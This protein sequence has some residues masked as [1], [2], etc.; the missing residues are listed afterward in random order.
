MT[1]WRV[2]AQVTRVQ[3][4]WQSSRQ[5]PTFYLDSDLQG[6]TGAEHAIR[7]AQEVIDP[8][9]ELAVHATVQEADANRLTL[10]FPGFPPIRGVGPVITEQTQDDTPPCPACGSTEPD[11]EPGC[12]AVPKRR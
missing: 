10:N 12:P 11:C 7:V 5:V 8:Y 1:L 6:I 3:D 4:G 2:T 9:A